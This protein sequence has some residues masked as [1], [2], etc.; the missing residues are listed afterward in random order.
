[1]SQ[2]IFW[3]L[4]LAM[5]IAVIVRTLTYEEIFREPREWCINM[6][7]T[8]RTLMARKFFYVF[9]CEYCA[10]H[11]ITLPFL[12]MTQFKLLIDDW[13]GC[14]I[15]WLALVLVANAYLNVYAR[16]RID[17]TSEKKNIEQKEKMI[18]KLDAD[19]NGNSDERTE[20][21]SE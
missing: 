9:T 2:Q 18:E 15:A 17:I 1:M 14:L 12:A 20:R 13:R 6:S 16:L 7:Q 8:C 5:P 3:L 10:S 21:L 11:W 19:L 4:I